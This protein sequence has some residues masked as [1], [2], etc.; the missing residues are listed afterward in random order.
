MESFGNEREVQQGEDWNLDILVSASN[1]EYI[2]YIITKDRTNPFFVITVASTKFEKNL[3]YVKS[4]WN[5]PLS[6]LEPIPTFSD[7]VPRY[8]GELDDVDDYGDLSSDDYHELLPTEPSDDEADPTYG[9]R[10]TPRLYQYTVESEDKDIALGHKPYHYFYFKYNDDSVE[11][12]DEYNCYIR[13]NFKSKDT[14]EWGSQNYLYQITL[15]DGY[16]M[17]DVLNNEYTIHLDPLDPLALKDWPLDENGNWE[18]TDDTPI[19]LVKARYEYVKVRWPDE[20][21]PDI[22]YDSP[23]GFIQ[24]PEPILPPTK[25]TVRNNL[26][27]LI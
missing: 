20:L 9:D 10:L 13:Q 22:D 25:L 19:N 21:Q 6:G 7:T 4:W 5:S 26:R 16:L 18:T 2:P 23:L 15:V 11:R 3:R 8:Y 14:A 24:V 12:I 17:K 1:T 27:R